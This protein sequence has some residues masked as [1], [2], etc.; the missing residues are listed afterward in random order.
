MYLGRI[1][2]LIYIVLLLK[3]N[4]VVGLLIHMQ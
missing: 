4:E 1:N 3:H 2:R